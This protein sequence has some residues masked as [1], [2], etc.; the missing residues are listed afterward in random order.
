MDSFL[1]ACLFSRSDAIWANGYNKIPRLETKLLDGTNLSQIFLDKIFPR[2]QFHIRINCTVAHKSTPNSKLHFELQ[3][4]LRIPKLHS[5]FQ[6]YTPNS[7]NSL[8][9]P[10][11][12]SEF[13][14]Y[15][16]NSKNSLRILKTHSEFLNFTANSKNSLRILKTHSEF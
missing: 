6:N 13:R 14:N 12:H 2:L 7:K 9:I 1:P 3:N 16:P 15:T 8:R 5:E 11:T 4:S 10:K